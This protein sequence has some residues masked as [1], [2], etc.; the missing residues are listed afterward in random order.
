MLV[1][2][3]DR[4][5]RGAIK[6]DEA[7]LEELLEKLL[8][9]FIYLSDK[10][11]YSELYRDALAKR[12]LQSKSASF[13]A[14]KGMIAKMKMQ[15]GAPFTTK[16]EGMVNDYNV[17]EDTE[18]KFQTH[19]RA[20]Q[21]RRRR[22]RGGG[23]GGRAAAAAARERRERGGGERGGERG[24]RGTSSSACRCHARLLA[25]AEEARAALPREM[26]S[27]RDVFT[28]TASSTATACSSGSSRSAT[29]S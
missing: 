9:L 28:C 19:R 29:C 25:D 2:Y 22:R 16:L 27:C 4:A 12:L 13:E 6:L 23:A 18:K 20:A 8:Q 24:A 11:L 3:A 5:L 7:Q 15:Q 10:D 1:A 14:E 21:G 17:G 26:A